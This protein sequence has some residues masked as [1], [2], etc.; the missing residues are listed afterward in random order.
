MLG[1]P[2]P[3]LPLNLPGQTQERGAFQS[4]P[5][6][7]WSAAAVKAP[8]LRFTVR[9]GGAGVKL[10]PLWDPGWEAWLQVTNS[11]AG[12]MGLEQASSDPPRGPQVMR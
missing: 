10:G 8:T 12:Q 1:P 11:G 2:I 5:C 6:K 7:G 4:G 9:R 3:L